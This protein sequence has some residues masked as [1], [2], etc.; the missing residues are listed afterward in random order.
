[1]F[2]SFFT[3]IDKMEKWLALIFGFIM[4]ILAVIQVIWRYVFYSP[5]VWSE[6][7]CR[8]AF[9]WVVFIGMSMVVKRRAHISVDYFVSRISGKTRILIDF[10]GMLVLLFFLGGLTISGIYLIGNTTGM[11]LTSVKVPIIL[12][13]FCV[14]LLG[15][16]MFLRYACFFAEDIKKLFVKRT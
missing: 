14:P 12:V 4:V 1:M 11:Y 8:V 7:I 5:L 10:F 9:I 16:V 3:M 2:Q 15:A 6:E 13:Y